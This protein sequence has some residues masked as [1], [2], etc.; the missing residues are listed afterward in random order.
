MKLSSVTKTILPAPRI[1]SI[2]GGPP[3]SDGY[4]PFLEAS[5]IDKP[6]LWQTNL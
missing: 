1:Q 6:P 4:Y 2:Q 3:I 5:L